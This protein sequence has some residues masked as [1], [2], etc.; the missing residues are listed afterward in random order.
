MII[1]K[2]IPNQMLLD[3]EDA[4]FIQL[5]SK[6][7][8][9]PIFT[10]R[11]KYVLVSLPRIGLSVYIFTLFYCKIIVLC[12]LGYTVLYMY[13]QQILRYNDADF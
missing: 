2:S 8:L 12:T 10:I 4:L 11:T 5:I 3:L 13:I 9:R 7:V 1:V 6:I